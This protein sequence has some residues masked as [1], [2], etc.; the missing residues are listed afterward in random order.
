MRI[1]SVLE[2][3][4]SDEGV[5]LVE[6]VVA[7]FIFALVS[8]GIIYGLISVKILTRDSRARQVATNLAAG[9]IDLVR[10]TSDLFTLLDRDRDV[11]LN[12]D[13]YHLH[14]A[15]QWVTDPNQDLSCG[16]GSTTSLRYKRVNVTVTWDGMRQGA[17]AVRADTLVQPAQ[18]I[19]DPSKGTIIVSV[20]GYDGT[21]RGGVSVSAAP[22]SPPNGALALAA[23]PSP[24]DAQGCSYI[25]KVMPGNYDVTIGKASYLDPAQSASSTRTVGVSAGQAV[26]VQFEYD[27]KATFNAQYAANY[28]PA[29]SETLRVPDQPTTTFTN[30]YGTFVSTPSSSALLTRAIDRYPFASGYDVFAGA[31]A[32]S[33]PVAWPSTTSGGFTW[34]GERQPAVAAVPGGSVATPVNLGIVKL[35]L[36]SIGT[37]RYLKAVS[38]TPPGGSDDPG[39]SSTTTYTFGAAQLPSNGNVTIALPYGS[40]LLYYGTGSASSGWTTAVA[41]A[42]MSIPD[43]TTTLS[44]VRSGNVVT[45]DP[46]SHS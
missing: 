5:T 26:A 25:L 34:T 23:A 44:K 13:T 35:S 14:R 39:C 20:M 30:T 17:Q 11:S 28:T 3:R 2:R 4:R 42:K 12:G 24:T 37:G 32:S 38:T 7:M 9:E 10:D 45:F 46:R 31:C 29:G 16:A 8:T 41:T 19:N 27:Q 22:S 33:D 18:K 21:G 36:G 40:W 43:P 1:A 15:T 6:V